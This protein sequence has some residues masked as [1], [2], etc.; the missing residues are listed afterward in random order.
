MTTENTSNKKWPIKRA[1][2][3][4]VLVILT[5]GGI[6][7]YYNFNKLLSN[8]LMNSFNSSNVSDV[9]ELKFENLHVSLLDGSIKVIN[10]SLLPREKPLHVYPYIN[11]LFRLK[12]EKLSLENVEIFKLLKSNQLKLKSVLIF[13]PEMELTLTG[14]RNIFLPFNDSAAVSL[15]DKEKKSLGAFNLTEFKLVN[16]RVHTT[17][18]GK[19]REFNIDDFNITLNDFGVQPHEGEF[20][21]S[22][23]QVTVSLGKFKGQLRQG[24]IKYIG[25]NDFK[26]G[27][28]SLS[29]QYTLDTVTYHFKDFTA[30]LNK[31]DIQTK[32]SIYQ[33]AINSFGLSYID[34]SIKIKGVNFKPNVSHAAI[35]KNYKNWHTEFSGTVE[36]IEIKKVNFDS[37]IFAKKIMIDE[38]ALDSIK[39]YIYKDKTKPMDKNRFPVYLGQTISNIPMPVHIKLIKATHLNLENTERKENGDIAKVNITHGAAELKNITNLEPKSKLIMTADAYINGVAHFKASLTFDYQKPQ[40]GY[41]ALIYKFNLPDLNPLILAYTPAKINKGIAD[42]ISFSGIADKTSANGTMTFLYHDLEIDLE[43]K[44][45]AKWKSSALAFV[46]NA[47]VNSSN[48]PQSDA[49]PRIVQ[50]HVE[51][52]RNKGFIN[53][54]I[55]SILGGLKETMFMSK[56]NRRTYKESKKRMKQ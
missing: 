36:T 10:V 32:D 56:E 29:V 23:K 15:N 28:D 16:A 43:L 54:L 47:I 6:V 34:K 19:Q 39:A 51:R 52:D 4:V 40:F 24:A 38:I 26:I 46:G 7:I 48:P 53:V 5:T 31:L 37:L 49:P 44:N 27:A 45:K 18:A 2:A 33:L 21:A 11:S 50:F 30:G 17:N 9:Y 25:L 3:I 20:Q 55:K 42:K 35:Q 12:T 8:A 14:E 22:V 13:K 41:E 1:I